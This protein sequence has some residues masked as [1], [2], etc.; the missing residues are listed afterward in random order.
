MSQSQY[1]PTFDREINVYQCD[2]YFMFQWFC[3]ISWGLFDVWA[4]YFV[5]MSQYDLMFDLKINVGH[6]DL[7][8]MVYWFCALMYEHHTLGFWV[9]W[10]QNKCRSLWFCVTWRLFD[11]WT[12]YFGI[13]SK[14]YRKFPKYSD[15]QK[16]VVTTL[17]LNYV[18]LPQ[19]NESKRCRQNGKQCTP[20]LDCSSRSSLIWVCT[21]RPW[22]AV[23]SG[24]ALFT[25]A[26]LSEN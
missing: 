24:S 8:F 13:I 10:P 12:S 4:S 18:A 17:K 11:V 5:I 3:L 25:Q 16:F 26:Y 21:G 9:I 6:F 1:D 20:W 14:Y 7:Y 23:S 15:T 2:L 19:S 22:G